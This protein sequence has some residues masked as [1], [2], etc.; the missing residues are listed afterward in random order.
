MLTVSIILLNNP[1]ISFIVY[2]YHFNHKFLFYM[3]II[4]YL[5]R[6]IQTN[7]VSVNFQS[8]FTR[9]FANNL[10]KFLFLPWECRILVRQKKN[11]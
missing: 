6:K 1:T 4:L 10:H 8:K 5:P 11:T 2:S 3:N 7:K 9:P